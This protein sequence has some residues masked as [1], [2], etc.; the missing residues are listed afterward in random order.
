MKMNA[1]E[2]MVRLNDIANKIDANRNVVNLLLAE[3]I[4]LLVDY[5]SSREDK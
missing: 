4:D 3:A 2:L 5:D 1:D